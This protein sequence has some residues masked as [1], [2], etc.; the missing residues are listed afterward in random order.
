MRQRGQS[1]VEFALVVPL[2]LLLMLG[3][4]DFS[5]LLF[6]YVSVTNGARELAR[7]VTITGNSLS[8][9]VSAFNNLTIIG[10]PLSPASSVTFAPTAGAGSGAISCNGSASPSSDP[11]CVIKVTTLSS[12]GGITLTNQAAAS[13]SATYSD[14]SY[15]FGPTGNGDFVTLM[16]LA[17]D[18]NG[19]LQGLIEVCRLP[20]TT[21]CTFAAGLTR[22]AYTDGQLQVDVQYVF[23][24]NP[25][26]QNRL[27]GVMDAGILRPTTLVT[28]SVRTYAE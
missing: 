28:T 8:T 4:I 25:L 22:S 19:S 18:Q 11:L 17:R 21:S 3:V 23:Q 7:S 14:T 27:A 13:G 24:H 10:G 5:R 15:K 26:F 6:T 2:F 20:Y 12:G 1:L 16:W 9:V